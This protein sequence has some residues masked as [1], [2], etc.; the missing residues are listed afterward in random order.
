MSTLR[1]SGRAVSAM[2]TTSTVSACA[3]AKRD[4]A[5]VHKNEQGA[6]RAL[7][8]VSRAPK[9]EDRRRALALAR[10]ELLGNKD[11][12]GFRCYFNGSSF[13]SCRVQASLEIQ[14]AVCRTPR[15]KLQI[16]SLCRGSGNS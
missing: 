16:I 5:L 3:Q 4:A 2:Q 8:L 6:I 14:R 9:H 1:C 12:A 7:H 11:D 10:E 13:R 15:G